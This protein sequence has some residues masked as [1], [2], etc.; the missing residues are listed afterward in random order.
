[1]LCGILW[2]IVCSA[3]EAEVAALF[4]N[5]REAKILRL[6]LEE[7]GHTQP[8]TPVDCD[9]SKYILLLVLQITHQ[10]NHFRPY[11]YGKP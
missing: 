5:M 11:R 4:L 8:A 10:K 1:M 3:A 7:M 9:N 2:L 6:V